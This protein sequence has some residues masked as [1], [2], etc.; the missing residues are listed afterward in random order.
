M[1]AKGYAR[2]AAGGLQVLRSCPIVEAGESDTT[3]RLAAAHAAVSA[4]ANAVAR[5]RAWVASV[6]LVVVLLVAIG[7]AL[8]V[9]L[10][11]AWQPAVMNTSDELRYVVMALSGPFDDPLAPGGYSIFLRAL[12]VASSDVAFTV[13]IQHLLGIATGLLMYATVRRLGAPVWVAAVASAALLV[14]L[15]QVFLEHA[16]LS[17]PLFAAVIVGV[18]Y[19]SVRALDS[20]RVLDRIPID[21]AQLWM[22]CAGALIGLSVWIRGAS[23]ILIPA[24]ALWLALAV[25]GS[26]GQRLGHAALGGGAGVLV[27]AIY[28]A[29]NWAAT[30]NFMLTQ[31]GASGWGLYPR[32]APF[33]DC[34][35]FEPPAKT[36][37]L[38]ERTP[39]ADRPGGDFYGWEPGSPAR[40]RFGH[41]PNGGD[42]LASFAR[43]A[44]VH[45][46]LVYASAV[47]GDFG[48]YFVPGFND[49]RV[50]SGTGY[51][52]M[53]VAYLPPEVSDI[54][55]GIGAYYSNR[56]LDVDGIVYT[57][58]DLQSVLR[59][60]PLIMLAAAALGCFALP[61]AGGRIRAGLVLFLL[62][63]VL[64]LMF[65]AAVAGY[66]ARYSVPV[67]GPLLAAGAIGA[68]VLAGRLRA[69]WGS[70]E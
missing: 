16:L 20:P 64:L 1:K 19:S 45:Q 44:I 34:N 8:R 43:A 33:A 2:G 7:V 40:R 38:C 68:W 36:A 27:L 5:A 51:G 25:R 15:D 17:E 32:T 26:P 48:R 28:F 31:P 21:T 3:G 52:H 13:A 54:Q 65:P 24:L 60:H 55:M 67:G 41:A 62:T 47:L 12:H 57:L 58:A 69:A 42:A 37:F 66:A 56:D 39:P 70:R 14:S 46:P 9:A 29:M 63:A 30:G 4:P 53:D 11:L 35:A 6:P 61:F 22:L 23:L 59:V 50:L 18:L 49:D 10:S